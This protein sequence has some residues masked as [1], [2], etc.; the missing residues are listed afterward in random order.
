MNN[1][2][3][4]PFPT[5]IPSYF[6]VLTQ[7]SSIAKKIKLAKKNAKHRFFTIALSHD[8]STIGGD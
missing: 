2:S 6:E 4:F 7:G 1:P 3:S 5:K 8:C